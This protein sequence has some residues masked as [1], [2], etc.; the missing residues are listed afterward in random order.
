MTLQPA[1]L[2]AALDSRETVPLDDIDRLNTRDNLKIALED[3]E[4]SRKNQVMNTINNAYKT[5]VK[6]VEKLVERHMDVSNILFI[7]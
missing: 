7:S 5:S 6:K 1:G 3:D 4:A 2:L